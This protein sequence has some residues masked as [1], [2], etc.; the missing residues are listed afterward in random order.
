[1]SSKDSLYFYADDTAEGFTVK[2]H[3]HIK[4]PIGFYRLELVSINFQLGSRLF[5]L[6]FGDD[7]AQVIT[8][9]NIPKHTFLY[10]EKVS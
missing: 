8:P 3:E 2:L 4:L 10:R 9:I 5:N 7:I 1:M 6:D